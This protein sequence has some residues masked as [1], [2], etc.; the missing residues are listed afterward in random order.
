MGKRKVSEGQPKGK[1]NKAAKTEA[2]PDAA[3]AAGASVDPTTVQVAAQPAFKNKE[4]VLILSS[5]GIIHRSAQELARILLQNAYYAF[6]Y[7]AGCSRF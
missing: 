6:L 1:R 4:K 5:R 2:E 7:T 3:T